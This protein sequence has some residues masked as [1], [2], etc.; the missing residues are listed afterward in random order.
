MTP[1]QIERIQKK[2]KAIR[3][4]IYDEKRLWGGYHDGRGLRYL[5]P[6]YY[7]KIPDYKGGLTYFRW[8]NKNFPDDGG[9]SEF[10]FEWTIILFKNGKLKDAESKAILSY[11]S[12]EYLFDKF[13]ERP[14]IPLKHH[15]DSDFYKIGFAEYLTYSHN[16][17]EL[18]DFATWLADFEKS[19]RFKEIKSVRL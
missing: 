7:L 4:A 18:H 13:F 12:N 5:P 19:E 16:Q 1:K 15:K 2:I 9:G 8:F 6:Q 14:I 11:F 3:K 17:S 10:L